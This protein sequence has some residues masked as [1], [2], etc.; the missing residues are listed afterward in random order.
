MS[1]SFYKTTQVVRLAGEVALSDEQA[2][3][4]ARRVKPVEGK[5]GVYQLDEPLDFKA[6]E[7]IGLDVVP[8]G[9]YRSLFGGQDGQHPTPVDPKTGE[10]IVR[11]EKKGDAKKGGEQKGQSSQPPAGGDGKGGQGSSD[12][13]NGGDGA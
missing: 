7:I 4:R 2:R 10:P 11:N 6:G 5:K 12:P 3:R 9:M 13:G 8:K 1:V